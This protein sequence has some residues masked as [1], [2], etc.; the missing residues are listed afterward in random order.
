MLEL[1]SK[2]L[3]S[4]AEAE[5]ADVWAAYPDVQVPPFMLALALLL[6]DAR[7]D[8]SPLAPLVR[9]LPAADGPVMRRMPLFFSR[10]GEALRALRGTD[11]HGLT[12]ELR[13]EAAQTHVE[14]VGPIARR[15]GSPGVG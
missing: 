4:S 9:S 13:E 5:L 12:Q 3:L 7:G 14:Y 2:L 10:K 1:P 6:H 15:A 11:A 8:A